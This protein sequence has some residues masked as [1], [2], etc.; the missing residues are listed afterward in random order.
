MHK[1]ELYKFLGIGKLFE[2]LY[3]LKLPCKQVYK[4]AQVP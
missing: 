3:S 4:K 2:I 1:N